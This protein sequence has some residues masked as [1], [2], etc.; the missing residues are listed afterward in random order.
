MEQQVS[1]LYQN[2]QKLVGLHR[3][4][5][6]SVRNEHDIL[7]QADVKAI[8]EMTTEKQM[9]LESIRLAE[10][11]RIKSVELLSSEWS[12]PVEELSLS[13]V[14]VQLQGTDQKQA[15][16]FRS[17]LNALT[18]LIQRITEQNLEN[19]KLVEAS[20]QHVHRMKRNVLGAGAPRASTYTAQGQPAQGNG[21]SRLISREI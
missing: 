5:M 14:I 7:V 11:D 3:R 6:D 10:V 16:Q 21:P 15:E 18:V 9:L 13:R 17:T 2:L 20:L 12:I 4:L 1:Q 19:R 8:Q